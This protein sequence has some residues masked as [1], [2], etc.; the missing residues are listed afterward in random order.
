MLGVAFADRPPRRA[1]V[2]DDRLRHQRGPG[3]V[4]RQVQPADHREDWHIQDPFGD[5]EDLLDPGGPQP[6]IRTRPK[7]RTLTTRACSVMY[8]AQNSIR[9]SGG[10]TAM[11]GAIT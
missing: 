9:G 2:A 6:L 8:P 3:R 1:R 4:D 7:P 5:P 11:A 10:S